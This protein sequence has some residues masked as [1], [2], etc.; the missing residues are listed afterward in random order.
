MADGMA[1]K[2]RL[3]LRLEELVSCTE[4][5]EPLAMAC[6]DLRR[7]SDASIPVAVA[8]EAVVEEDAERGPGNRSC[9]DCSADISPGAMDLAKVLVSYGPQEVVFGSAERD[10]LDVRSDG[11]IGL[12]TPRTP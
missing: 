11:P 10:K 6:D 7:T 12:G 4:V 3:P 1:V 5:A 9:R 8:E 2:G